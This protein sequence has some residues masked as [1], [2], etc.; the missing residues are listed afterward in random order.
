M[1]VFTEGQK[2]KIR[3]DIEFLSELISDISSIVGG[4]RGGFTLSSDDFRQN[5]EIDFLINCSKP[6][7][8]YIVKA[9]ADFD[10]EIRKQILDTIDGKSEHLGLTLDEYKKLAKG[11]ILLHLEKYKE[12]AAKSPEAIFISN[13]VNSELANIL[14]T[15]LKESSQLSSN[16]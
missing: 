16:L 14:H 2:H 10:I 7:E 9:F 11:S 3:N 12:L 1:Q 8:K 6:A 15:M 13:K 4:E 5:F